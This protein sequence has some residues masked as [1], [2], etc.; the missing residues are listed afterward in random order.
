MI[1]WLLQT[2]EPLHSD[3]ENDRPM[4]A[5]NL[6]NELINKGHKVILWSSAFYHQTKTHRTKIYKKIEISESLEVRLIP[7]S[8]YK[9]NISISRLYD[10]CLLAWNL[11]KHLKDENQPPEAAFIGYP[12][13]EVA[14]VM[15]SWL[16]KRDVPF[17]LDV[18]D[19][20]P[21]IL[22]ESFPRS[23]KVFARVLLSP[24]YILAKKAMQNA[25][26]ICGQSSSFVKW[27]LTFSNKGRSIN[28]FVAPLTTPDNIIG[29]EEMVN[30]VNWWSRQGIKRKSGL[31]IIFVGSF[32]RVFD[33]DAIFDSA[34]LMND[35]KLDCEFVLCGDGDRDSEL[36][37]KAED[38]DNVKIISWIDLPKIRAL[39]QISNATIAPYKSTDDFTISVPNKIID[40]LI[41]GLPILS[42]LKGEVASLISKH[43]VGFTYHNN[44]DLCDCIRSLIMDSEL[45]KSMSSNAKKL[46]ES[47][48]EFN[49]V[50]DGLVRHLESLKIH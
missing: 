45:Q 31:R 38:H 4:R 35:Q 22:L 43:N 36:R 34:R 3:Q 33:F 20:W 44:M 32:S 25:T 2:G 17:L 46:Y 7:S 37:L 24:Y 14:Y 39:S 8:G 26:G 41:L 50:Y 1:I 12:P 11:R 9:T 18:K 27:A 10:H 19:Q 49:N 15:G 23:L 40:S 5:M 29:S 28:D 48:F 21:N 16:K 13:I 30:A 6:A 47:E 42:P